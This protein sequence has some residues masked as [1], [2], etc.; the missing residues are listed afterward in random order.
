MAHIR[1]GKISATGILVFTIT[2]T[3]FGHG[4][5]VNKDTFKNINRSLLRC[6]LESQRRTF[7]GLREMPSVSSV[8]LQLNSRSAVSISRTH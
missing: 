4:F 2:A 7:A 1:E 5:E 8:I 3:L 6:G